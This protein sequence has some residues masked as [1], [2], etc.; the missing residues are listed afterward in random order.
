M[1]TIIAATH[2]RHHHHYHHHH[3]HHRL[4][5]HHDVGIT[6]RQELRPAVVDLSNR[7]LK[8]AAKFAAE[9]LAG[10]RP[11]PDT[12]EKKPLVGACGGS[13]CCCC[14]CCCCFC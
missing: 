10:L 5:D 12:T 14:C 2:T 8:L 11:D 9:Q 1:S 6:I 7:G 4:H 13:S 3:H